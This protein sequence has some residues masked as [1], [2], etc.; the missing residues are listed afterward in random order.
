MGQRIFRNM[1]RSEESCPSGLATFSLSDYVM[2][3]VSSLRRNKYETNFFSKIDEGQNL[4]QL[5]YPSIVD[6]M[7]SV[8][9]TIHCL[10]YKSHEKQ[11]S[12]VGTYVHCLIT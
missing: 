12:V 4:I 3:Y 1:F 8:A 7:H 5:L 2:H 6:N 9:L 10:M 11:L